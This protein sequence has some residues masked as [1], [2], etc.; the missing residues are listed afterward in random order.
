M[1]KIDPF[2]LRSIVTGSVRLDGGAMFGVV[3]KVLWEAVTDVDDSNRILLNTRTLLAIDRSQ[4]RVVLVDTGCG[5]KWSQEK[6]DRFAVRYD[7]AA[8]PN[9]LAD[10][11][12]SVDDVTDVVIT[13]LHFDHN[14]GLTHWRDEQDG[15]TRPTYRNARHWVHRGQ[16]E[17]AH[18]PTVKDRASYLREDFTVLAEEGLLE[19]LD[20]DQP[21][22]L[23]DGVTWFVSNGHTPCQLHPVFGS[24]RERLIFI[25]DLVPT[26]EH[27]RLGWVMAYD[28]YPMTTIAERETIYRRC[29]DEGLLLAFPHDPKHG[30]IALDGTVER[31]TVA[32]AL[33][34]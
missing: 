29:F 34:L 7:P 23:L 12:L 11:S 28:L 33:P 32:R 3:P 9:A 31:P 8:I 5:T 20:H 30:G 27:I 24:G 2:E 6:A 18:E 19:L 14:G 4:R 1:L 17:H 25:G 22:R 13:H 10:M 15:P 26:A 16:W 21:N